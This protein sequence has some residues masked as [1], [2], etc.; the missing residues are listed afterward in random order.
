MNAVLVDSSVV[1]DIYTGDPVFFDRS[2]RCLAA[3]GAKGDLLIDEIVYAEVS[4][5]FTR[6]EDL[7]AALNGAGFRSAAIPREALFLAGKAF[8]AYKRRGGVKNT[9]LP[10]FFIGAHAAVAGIPLITRDPSR[11]RDAFPGVKIIE[12]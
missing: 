9:P 3:R 1:L 6:I 7:E 2:L 8:L 5:G 4:I 11:V 12:P 10:D